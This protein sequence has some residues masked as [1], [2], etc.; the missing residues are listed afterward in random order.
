MAKKRYNAV[1]DMVRNLT[2]D[3]EF[4]AKLA[5]EISDQRL[6]KVLFMMRCG[7]VFLA[8]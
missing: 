7:Q 4:H 6:A 5:E 3:K 2:D 8:S 1:T